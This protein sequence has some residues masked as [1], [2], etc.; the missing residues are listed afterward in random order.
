MI[1][2]P[3]SDKLDCMHRLK[4]LQKRLR[5]SSFAACLFEDSISVS[6]YTGLH[7]SAAKLYVD[8]KGSMLF[9]DPRYW[10]SA[11]ESSPIPV[12][13]DTPENIAAYIE[14]N[15][16]RQ[17][18][19]DGKTIS[20]N[21]AQVLLHSKNCTY[22]ACKELYKGLRSVKSQE[23]QE[24]LFLSATLLYRGFTHICQHIREGVTE[25]ELAKLFELF[26]LE[27]GGDG[28]GFEPIIAFGP[29]S[30]MPHYRSG[31]QSLHDGDL[32]LIDIGVLR[33]GY[34]SDMT[35]TRFFGK[36]D[37]FFVQVY[38]IVREAQK[39]A[40]ALCF[41]GTSLEELDVA[42]RSVMRAHQMEEYYL[43]S[44]G[45][46]VGLEIHEFPRIH[47]LGEDRKTVLEE[48]MVIT[49]EPGLYF[50]GKGGIRYEDTIIIEK[51]GYRNLY[52]EDL[53]PEI[54]A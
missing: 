46:G 49:I 40:L 4:K 50:P 44:L 14:G 30:A 47:Y 12:S 11:Q 29:H 33:D 19:F 20:Y 36:Q 37:P 24:K 15:H 53:C 28:L 2:N 17:I 48:G 21:R 45:H 23:E 25:R 38:Q 52:P 1:S 34:H 7:F 8:R 54:T 43:H 5:E 10:E 13:L 27:Q 3:S 26:C 31:N 18:A 22:V 41:P 35:R 32:V 39:N 51:D 16:L 9:I 42:A 6:Y